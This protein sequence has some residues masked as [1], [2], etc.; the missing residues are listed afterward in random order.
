MGDFLIDFRPPAARRLT[1][2]AERLRFADDFRAQVWDSESV[3]I[4]YSTNEHPELWAPYEVPGAGSVV[5]LAGRIDLN[6]AAWR[7][8]E[9]VPG[10]GGLAARHI[11]SVYQRGGAA[12]LEALSGNFGV[13]VWD[14]PGG[15]LHVL[16]DPAGMLPQFVFES[17]AGPV[18]ATHPDVLADVTDQRQQW[19]EVSMAEFVLAGRVTAP[20]TYY[21][22]IRTEDL[23]TRRTYDLRAPVPT[24]V[25]RKRYF[26]LTYQPRAG[27]TLESVAEE[28]SAAFQGAVQRRTLPRLGPGVIA[29]SGGLDSRTILTAA[30]ERS[31]LLTLCCHNEINHEFRIAERIARTARVPFLPFQRDF[32][33]YGRTAEQGIRLAAGMGSL[34]NNHF[35]GLAD[36]LREHGIRNMLT[37]CYCD[38]LFKA[39]PLNRAESKLTGLERLGAFNHEYYFEHYPS[40]TPLAARVHQRL[41]ENCPAELRNATDEEKVFRLEVLRTFPLAFEGDNLQRVVPQRALGWYVPICDREVLEVY[42]RIPYGMKLNR[43]LFR[44]VAQDICGPEVSAIPDANTGAPLGAGLLRERWSSLRLRVESKLA[45]LRP[46]VATQGSWLNWG[47][48]IQSSPVIRELWSRRFAESAPM[49]EAVAGPTQVHRDIAGYREA[50]PFLLVHLLSLK[51]WIETRL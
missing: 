30:P 51:L 20:F 49:L 13:V 25:E 33:Y 24:L 47:Y 32:E 11:W 35:L 40:S 46:T 26:E 1:P 37:G 48:Y 8:A 10:P 29:L 2:A 16:S 9:S 3:G 27:A 42:R 41:E 31:H 28:L 19:D 50:D 5:C 7:A 14:R 6:E 45:K 12:A 36:T 44:R 43:R 15:R 38:Y 17:A 39:L 34:A 21:R 22:A 23:G 18:I 4:A